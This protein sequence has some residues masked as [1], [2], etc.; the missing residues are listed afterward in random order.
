MVFDCLRRIY[1]LPPIFLGELA[2]GIPPYLVFYLETKFSIDKKSPSSQI[3]SIFLCY[4]PF[5]MNLCKMKMKVIQVVFLIDTWNSSRTCSRS[6]R[7]QMFF[8]IGIL[9]K[10]IYKRL[11]HRSF[12]VNIAKFLRTAFFIE[13][14]W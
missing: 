10:L 6:S 2:F 13:H 4:A 3:Q 1:P 12:P 5:D 8:K 7:S 9:K 14:I 11:Q